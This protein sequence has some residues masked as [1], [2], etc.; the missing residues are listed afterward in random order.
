MTRSNIQILLSLGFLLA[1]SACSSL[2]RGLGATSTVN[3]KDTVTP[4]SSANAPNPC[5]ESADSLDAIRANALATYVDKNYNTNKRNNISNELFNHEAIKSIGTLFIGAKDAADHYKDCSVT[6]KNY[7]GNSLSVG[8]FLNLIDFIKNIKGAGERIEYYELSYFKGDF[9]DRFGSNIKPPESIEKN[10]DQEFANFFTVFFEAVIDQVEEDYFVSKTPKD[11]QDVVKVPYYVS[12]DASDRTKVDYF[13]SGKSIGEPLK[14]F[15]SAPDCSTDDLAVEPDGKRPVFIFY[16]KKEYYR[17][18]FTDSDGKCRSNTSLGPLFVNEILFTPTKTAEKAAQAAANK[19]AADAAAKAAKSSKKTSK[20]GG[21]ADTPSDTAGTLPSPAYNPA[22]MT[23]GK[24]DAILYLSRRASTL[25]G[26]EAGAVLGA[27]GG[28]H[29]G[30]PFILGKV[31]IGD[32]KTVR[33][34]VQAVFAESAERLTLGFSESVL[35]KVS[36]DDFFTAL[37][38]F[39]DPKSTKSSEKVTAGATRSDNKV[40][41]SVGAPNG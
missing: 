9:V 6:G 14:S 41:A 39:D 37:E 8:N 40:N 16:A 34:I 1:L 10:Q 29:I 26:G 19:D 23:Q 5:T 2:S 20:A 17:L 30:L 7:E 22:G 13:L 33:D 3:L 4:I 15:M 25:S 12:V 21:L 18:N 31:S 24:V 36:A 11:T 27:F 38:Q 32:N 35:M 28:V